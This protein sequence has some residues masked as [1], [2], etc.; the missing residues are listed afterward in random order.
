MVNTED[1]KA[2]TASNGQTPTRTSV[3]RRFA[4]RG[5]GAALVAA[6]S[7]VVS[8]MTAPPASAYVGANNLRNWETGRC[9]SLQ[10]AYV[11]TDPCELGLPS[12]TWEPIFI[13]HDDYDVVTLRN[14]ETHTCLSVEDGGYVG[15]PACSTTSSRQW[16]KAT[17]TGWDKVEFLSL[18]W[19]TCLDSNYYGNVYATL[20]CN[21]GGFQKWKLGY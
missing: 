13:R 9:L 16:F 15:H 2:D 19:W 21:G 17:G 14:A 1:P 5:W 18:F 3:R 20:T 10:G 8:L 11:H 7:L 6:L 12:Q 4:R